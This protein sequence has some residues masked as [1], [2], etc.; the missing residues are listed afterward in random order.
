MYHQEMPTQSSTR[1]SDHLGSPLRRRGLSMLCMA[2]VAFAG[3]QSV[4]AQQT[5]TSQKSRSQASGKIDPR[6][7][8]RIVQQAH[9]TRSTPEEES[10]WDKPA[11]QKRPKSSFS[12]PARTTS[13]SDEAFEQEAAAPT[14]RRAAHQS[15]A[16]ERA[17]EDNSGRDDHDRP[18][19]NVTNTHAQ[20]APVRPTP[21]R[22]TPLA[23][24]SPQ[25]ENSPLA[26]DVDAERTESEQ[27]NQVT[28]AGYAVTEKPAA[29][30]LDL[31]DTESNVDSDTNSQPKVA[32]SEIGVGAEVTAAESPAHVIM[33]AV[34]W[35]VIALCLFSLGALGVRRWQRQRGL[36]P[37]PNS[38]S[39]VL[40][41][42]SLGPGK[43]VS[44]IEMA[45][46]RALVAS[47]AGGI[48]QLVLA[49]SS[50]NDDFDEMEHDMNTKP[51]ASTAYQLS[52]FRSHLPAS[53]D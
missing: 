5:S 25:S 46:Y 24:N 37:T 26:T 19:A 20:M 39:R 11:P 18:T 30:F 42:L 31:T 1:R 17:A 23:E 28:A 53:A 15:A 47:D 51:V 50:F 35:V 43:T 21:L 12:P 36:L 6:L 8:E 10:S 38:R 29:V 45:G 9:A 48:R 40:E 44:L 49:S 13:T 7:A 41:T 27:P 34:A 2:A 16:Q 52:D 3:L 4:S 33:R 14:I 22:P 32:S